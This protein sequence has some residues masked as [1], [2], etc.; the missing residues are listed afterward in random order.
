MKNYFEIHELVPPEIFNFWGEERS[1]WW[2]SQIQWDAANLFRELVGKSVK[3]NDYHWGGVYTE[4]GTR[5]PET[6]TGGG[7]S[8]HK[9]KCAIDVKVKG[10]SSF[11]MAEI[12]L[13]N[14][15]KF[16]EIGVTTIEDPEKTQGEF[17]DWLHMDGRITK[18]GSIYVVN[19]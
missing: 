13:Q 16:L 4:S 1:Y 2:T 5:M 11:E 8:Q 9:F 10:M 6:R 3:I 15:K 7:L 18:K 12:V 14:Q 17:Q 19:P